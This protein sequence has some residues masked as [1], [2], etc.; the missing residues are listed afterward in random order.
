MLAELFLPLIAASAVFV[1]ERMDAASPSR[2]WKIAAITYLAAGGILV[3]PASIPILPV[4]SLPAYARTFG[5]LYQPVKDFTFP[6]SDY[7][8]EFSNRIG[9]DTLVE[10]VAGV[11]ADLPAEDQAKAGI[12]GDWYGTAGAIDVLGP[13]Y[14]LPHAVSGHLTYYLW[15]PGYSW[16]VMILVTGNIDGLSSFF[17]DCELKAAVTNPYAMPWN[18]PFIYVCR[19]PKM[20][21]EAIWSYVKNY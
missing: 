18:N 19:E 1:E 15:G 6:K 17:T 10:S 21:P 8:Q 9:W 2:G 5:F 14:G 13:K 20:S 12:W 4:E 16:D 11:Y 7:P 3:A